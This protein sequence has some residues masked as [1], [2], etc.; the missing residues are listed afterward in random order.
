MSHLAVPQDDAAVASDDERIRQLVPD[1]ALNTFV[2]NVDIVKILA[3]LWTHQ[4]N[5]LWCIPV[6][7]VSS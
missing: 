7:M 2:E 1:E 6:T 5:K 4:V 3:D